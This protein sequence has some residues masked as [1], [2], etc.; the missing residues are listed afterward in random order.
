MQLYNKQIDGVVHT[1]TVVT[2]FKDTEPIRYE[3]IYSPRIKFGLELNDWIFT[4]LI[5][6]IL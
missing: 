1:K 5:F 3:I 2:T 4:K 6:C